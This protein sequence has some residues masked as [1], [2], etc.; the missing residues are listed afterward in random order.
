MSDAPPLTLDTR[1]QEFS[2][3]WRERGPGILICVTVA[4]A[5][6]LLSQHYGAPQMLF[7]LLLGM[8]FNFLSEEGPCVTGIQFSATT[9]L[10]FGVALLG[11]RITIDQVL[12]LGLDT[13]ALLAGGVILTI[14]FGIGASKLMGRGARFG[15]LTGGAVAICG[16]SAALA[17]A[18]ILPKSEHGERDTIF[19]VIAVTT[20]STVAMVIYPLIAGLMGL[21]DRISGIFL[22]GT[23]HDV[24]Q[25]VGAGYTIS[26][27]SGDIATVT[28]LFR[29]SMLVPVVL[30]LSVIF[31]S[32]NKS[33]GRAPLPLFVLGFCALVALNS[34]GVVPPTIHSFIV[35]LSRWCLVT[36]IAALGIKTAL[37]AMMTIGYQ[38]VVVVMLETVF[39]ALWVLGGILY[40]N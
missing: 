12:G 25:V 9:L 20:F 13:V 11:L 39:I 24:A 21:E 40:L 14:L 7:A 27:Q 35:D 17:I 19:T 22:G 34:S 3:G 15:T 10:R 31:R 16:A 6:Q 32:D 29:V 18:A 37:K 36:A 33:A 1:F 38:P 26:E 2:N 28:K 5:A 4:A 23:I 8:A 30:V